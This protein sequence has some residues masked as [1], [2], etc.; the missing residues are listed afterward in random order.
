[1]KKEGLDADDD[2]SQDSQKPVTVVETMT[3]KRLSGEDA[4]TLGQLYEWLQQHPGWEAVESDDESEDEDDREG[5]GNY[6]E[7]EANILQ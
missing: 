1:M 5:R 3:G 6:F 4:P 7:N 2:G